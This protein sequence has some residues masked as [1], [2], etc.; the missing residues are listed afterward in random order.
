MKEQAQL[1]KVK[2]ELIG[3]GGKTQGS[4][5]KPPV[6]KQVL[7]TETT[8]L[9]K[10]YQFSTDGA[11]SSEME[12]PTVK[13]LEAEVE[14]QIWAYYK[15]HNTHWKNINVS[16]RASAKDSLKPSLSIDMTSEVRLPFAGSV[17]S[18][19]NS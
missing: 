13:F 1:V 15:T 16:F 4:L 9:A 10:L 6:E 14:K 3:E 5:A 12:L 7:A 17:T 18:L 8:T 2:K 11:L 19:P